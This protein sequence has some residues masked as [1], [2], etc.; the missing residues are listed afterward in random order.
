VPERPDSIQFHVN[1]AL[2]NLRA[3]LTTCCSRLARWSVQT[4][5]HLPGALSHVLVGGPPQREEAEGRVARQSH[6]AASARRPSGDSAELRD[7]WGFGEL[8]RRYRGGSHSLAAAVTLA[9]G[10]PAV[11]TMSGVNQGSRGNGE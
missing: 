2:F 3:Q 4:V 6:A 5:C 11:I 9:D 7:E 1:P 10:S 8:G